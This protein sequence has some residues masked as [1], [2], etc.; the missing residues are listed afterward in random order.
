MTALN[1][2]QRVW[3]IAAGL[4]ALGTLAADVQ[5][6]DQVQGAMIYVR[7][8]NDSRSCVGSGM[9]RGAILVNGPALTQPMVVA[10]IGYGA[11]APVSQL[12]WQLSSSA[13]RLVGEAGGALVR[14]SV[15]L[16]N[17][18]TMPAVL[19]LTSINGANASQ[20]RVEGGC[21][22]GSVLQAGTSCEMTVS[23]L[24]N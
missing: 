12:S 15:I 8:A 24:P 6:Q 13:I 3:G 14:R 17:P 19:S 22:V 5:A 20:F 10:L 21:L 16:N 18:G 4:L 23:F 9:Q 1:D 7:L 11:S 2:A